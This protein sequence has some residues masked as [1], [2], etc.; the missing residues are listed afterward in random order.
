MIRSFAG[1]SPG[2][3]LIACITLSAV[4]YSPVIAQTSPPT[5]EGVLRALQVTLQNEVGAQESTLEVSIDSR[6]LTIFRIN[7]NQ[8]NSTHAGRNNEASAIAAAVVKTMF[9][10]PILREMHTILVRY[11]RRGD[12]ASGETIIDTV[13]FRRDAKGLFPLHQS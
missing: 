7:S 13:E 3:F 8:N 10:E 6:V 12:A 5:R 9:N 1:R 4:S 11:L 2:F